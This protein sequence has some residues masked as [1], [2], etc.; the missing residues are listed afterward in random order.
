VFVDIGGSA[1][2]WQTMRL[3][4]NYLSM[5]RPRVLVMRN[6]RLTSFVSSLEWAEPTPSRH[7]WSQP[8]QAD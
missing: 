3:A 2:A 6:T 5:F 8:E 4:R 7:Y 1:P